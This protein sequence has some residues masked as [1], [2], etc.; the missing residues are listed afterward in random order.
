[1]SG[2]ADAA[3]G[4]RGYEQSYFRSSRPGCDTLPEASRLE[5]N[6]NNQE[7]RPGEDDMRDLTS[8][9]AHGIGKYVAACLLAIGA[10]TPAFAGSVTQP[11]ETVG[12]AAGVPLKPGVYFIDTADWGI[13]STTP[14][15][16]TLGVNI[17]I[18]AWATPWTLYGGRVQFLAAVPELEAGVRNVTYTNSMYNPGV[19]GQVAWELGNGFAFS[20]LIGG[21]FDVDG[22]LAWS[23]TSLNQRAAL[24]YT[25]NG[26]DLTANVIYGNQFSQFTSRPQV[27]PCGPGLAFGCNPDFLNV[28]G[29][30]THTFGKW[31]FGLVGF[32]STDLTRPI[33]TYLKQSQIA[34]GG[35]VGYNFGPLELQAYVT[36]DVY[37]QNYGGY[38]TRAWFRLVI[39]LWQQ[40]EMA[41]APSPMATKGL[42]R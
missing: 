4:S 38:D 8:R 22:S 35:L 41:P 1:V 10:A 40:A 17:P 26:W 29:T 36:R 16:T 27:S 32:G 25:A 2:N 24:S 9:F 5:A 19:F 13:R 18:L 31:E 6:I 37:Q 7:W 14:N 21:Y 12:I 11:G 33:S 39:P 34:L 3:F 15:N 42:P 30:A 23:S 20:Y 28:D